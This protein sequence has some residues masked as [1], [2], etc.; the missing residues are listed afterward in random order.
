VNQ[1]IGAPVAAGNFEGNGTASD[2][3][4][5]VTNGPT[6]WR[7]VQGQT[8]GGPVPPTALVVNGI[9]FQGDFPGTLGTLEV[10]A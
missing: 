1:N 2:I 4:V 9:S 8:N 5:G 7:A 3:L 6:T 10:G